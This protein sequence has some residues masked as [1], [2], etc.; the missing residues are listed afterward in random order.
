MRLPRDLS[1]IDLAR[2]LRRVGYEIVRQSGSH[3]RMTRLAGAQHHVT[4]PAH[5][6]LKVGTLAAIL[7]DVASQLKLSRDDLISR[8]F[9]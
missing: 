6:T 4:I 7:S 3:I 5:D 1:G 9:D 2:A 8:L